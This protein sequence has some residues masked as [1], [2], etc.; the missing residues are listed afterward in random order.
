M[1]T[2]EEIESEKIKNF[3]DPK[4]P[5][6]EKFRTVAPGTFRHSQNVSL[7]CEAVA[8]EMDLD[9]LFMKVCSMY[10]DIGKM[11]NPLYFSENQNGTN[12]HENI[13]P[14]ISYEIISKHVGDGVVILL[15]IDDMPKKVMEVVSQHH[16]DTVIKYFY[17]KD[18]KGVK[19][20][21]RYKCIQPQTIEAAILMIC[22]SIEATA[23]SLSS[24]GKLESQSERKSL[25]NSTIQRLVEDDQLDNMRVGELKVIKRVLY[26]EIENIYHKREEYPSEKEENRSND[27]ISMEEIE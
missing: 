23:R 11:N 17:E 16:G 8:V 13:P 1:E 7:L 6:L 9:P 15:N 10:H 19:D 12:Y 24:N 25:I 3:V 20:N 2:I 18:E 22:D 26:K 21:Y 14:N 4:F 27:S 5:L